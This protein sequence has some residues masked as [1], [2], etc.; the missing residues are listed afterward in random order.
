MAQL[1]REVSLGEP[2]PRVTQP[3]GKKKTP[4]RRGVKDRRPELRGEE[5]FLRPLCSNRFT[6]TNAANCGAPPRGV[7]S[8]R[9]R[10]NG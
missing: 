2:L 10:D 1:R 8:D 4:V 6:A 5:N 3:P 7:K 9:N